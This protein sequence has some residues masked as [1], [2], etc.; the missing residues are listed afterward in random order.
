MLLG[1]QSVWADDVTVT[2]G[3]VLYIKNIKPDNDLGGACWKDADGT[4]MYVKFTPS[5]GTGQSDAVT[6]SRFDGTEN[7]AGTVYKVVVPTGTWKKIQLF[8]GSSTSV[9]WNHTNEL[10]FV[11]GKNVLTGYRTSTSGSASVSWDLL[12]VH[13]FA[14]T[15]KLYI[16]NFKP[17]GWENTFKSGTEN[18][19]AYCFG[20]ET[21]T[22]PTWSGAAKLYRGRDNW[23]D[24]F[25]EIEMPAGTFCKVIITRGTGASFNDGKTLNQSNDISFYDASFSRCVLESFGISG[26]TWADP[27]WIATPDF[28]TYLSGSFWTVADWSSEKFSS[29]G[30]LTTN[31]TQ[32]GDRAFKLVCADVW[33]GA[34]DLSFSDKTTDA[35]MLWGTGGNVTMTVSAV[36]YYTFVWDGSQKLSVISPNYPVSIG[37]SGYATL[38]LPVAVTVPAGVTAYYES[39]YTPQGGNVVDVTFTEITAGNV[40][41]ANTPVIIKGTASTNPTFAYNASTADALGLGHFKGV[42]T[43]T[44]YASLDKDESD[45][46]YVLNKM[47]KVGFYQLSSSGN[48]AAFHCYFVVEGGPL[49]APAIHMWIEDVNGATAIP[50]FVEDNVTVET[51]VKFIENGKLFIEKNGVVYDATGCVVR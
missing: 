6:A 12:P 50:F 44:A 42:R 23:K 38:C 24:A 19:Y 33:T 3:D 25:Y 34:T 43:E 31:I 35:E 21:V 7:N 48:I 49:A 16:K 11:S 36:G 13:T 20:A 15:E 5:T 27:S 18:I 2:T 4:V 26:E 45:Y 30:I 39:A 47:D 40:I 28:D 1:A 9:D 29:D 32:I 37:A 51:A 41:P 46:V 10:A 8:R 22:T 17:S 14:G